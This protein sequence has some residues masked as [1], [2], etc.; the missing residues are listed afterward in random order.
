M[1]INYGLP[2]YLA[3]AWYLFP[4]EPW[5]I[6]VFTFSYLLILLVELVNTAV[7][8]MIDRIHPAEHPLIGASKDIAS[9]AVL[10]AFMFGIVV[11]FVLIATRIPH[12]A[13]GVLIQNTF[14]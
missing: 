2:M 11:V 4:F 5:E 3:I 12:G 9:A 1:E 6:I 14:V 8:K 13:T 10:V 7:E